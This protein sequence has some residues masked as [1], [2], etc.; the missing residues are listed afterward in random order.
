[1]RMKYLGE[2]TAS[3]TVSVVAIPVAISVALAVGIDPL[4]ALISSLI[5]LILSRLFS[6]TPLM[7]TG[8][9]VALNIAIWGIFNTFGSTGLFWV[10]FMSGIIQT[11]AALSKLGRQVYC[12][13]RAVIQGMMCGVGTAVIAGQTL[14]AFTKSPRESALDSIL[15][16]A[17]SLLESLASGGIPPE[18][19]IAFSTLATIF[20]FQYLCPRASRFLSPIV[21]SIVLVSTFCNL[22][23]IEVPRM[24]MSFEGFTLVDVP[25]LLGGWHPD[26]IFPAVGLAFLSSVRSL[27]FQSLIDGHYFRTTTDY[28]RELRIQGM[29]NILCGLLCS[30]P[31]SGIMSLSK[32]QLGIGA[33]K[34][35]V[36]DF[37]I[38]LFILI[39]SLG[40]GLFEYI[41]LAVFPGILIYMGYVLIDVEGLLK[42]FRLSKSEFA[43]LAATA[44]AMIV[45][46][47]STGMFLGLCF[48][49][50]RLALVLGLDFEYGISEPGILKIRGAL[51]FVSLP[52]LSAA[53]QR[54]KGGQADELTL[55][56]RHLYYIDCDC[57]DYL[58]REESQFQQRGK[59]LC[60]NWEKMQ[61]K[62]H[63]PLGS[64]L[65]LLNTLESTPNGEE[66]EQ[67]HG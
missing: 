39:P 41:P 12:I 29:T 30:L 62:I 1:M 32:I 16:I 9:N 27:S 54:A 13:P 38:V 52:R 64:L 51:T 66:G 65:P 22:L 24:E 67:N 60:I 8:P 15:S 46:G 20:A 5:A 43:L 45:L 33:R 63:K 26:Y 2:I 11:A 34:R 57:L 40:A 49:L 7:F 59:K 19:P 56:C 47:F 44:A 28:D 6:A 53:I 10:V 48:S 21:V 36:N 58:A 61:W 50:A 25:S 55:D 14:V 3:F 42:T 23:G 4:Y 35:I 37:T 31:T 18:V 17:P